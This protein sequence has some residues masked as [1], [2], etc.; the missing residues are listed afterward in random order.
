[1]CVSPFPFSFSPSSS[2]FSSPSFPLFPSLLSLSSLLASPLFP[3]CFAPFPPH[4]PSFLLTSSLFPLCF[5]A[6]LLRL[7]FSPPP[8]PPPLH[9]PTPEK[10]P[11]SFTPSGIPGSRAG[12]RRGGGRAG[13]RRRRRRHHCGKLGLNWEAAAELGDEKGEG[14]RPV[15]A[16]GVMDGG[17]RRVRLLLPHTPSPFLTPPPALPFGL[18]MGKSHSKNKR[19]VFGSLKKHGIILPKKKKR[20]EPRNSLAPHLGV[21]DGAGIFF[22]G[23]GWGFCVLCLVKSK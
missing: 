15:R 13:Y 11:T 8:I 19:A 9:P 6:F 17:E 20:L 16:V 1:M 21:W 5:S 2:S 23:F 12:T 3:L 22:P 18:K 7:I 14:P 10:G 4:F